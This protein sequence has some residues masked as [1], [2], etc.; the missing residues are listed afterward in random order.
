MKVYKEVPRFDPAD[1][2]QIASVWKICGWLCDWCGK[3]HQNDEAEGIETCYSVHEVGGS[4]PMYDEERIKNHPDLS[5]YDFFQGDHKYFEFC[6]DFYKG[7]MCEQSMLAHYTHGNM[8]KPMG[9]YDLLYQSR[10]R[11]LEKALETYTYQQL[12]L[13]KS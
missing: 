3:Y 6:Q 7:D 2:K 4:E 11:M 5:P 8:I 13:E 10:I 1:G 12:G 9:L